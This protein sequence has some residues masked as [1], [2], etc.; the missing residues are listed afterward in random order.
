MRTPCRVSGT[1]RFLVSWA[2]FENTDKFCKGGAELDSGI[3]PTLNTL[4]PLFAGLEVS[5]TN[6]RLHPYGEMCTVGEFGVKVVALT[7]E[8]RC[9]ERRTEGGR[10]GRGGQDKVQIQHSSS[11]HINM[12]INTSRKADTKRPMKYKLFTLIVY[13]TYHALM[14]LYIGV[15]SFPCRLNR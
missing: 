11:T 8:V 5:S 13:P 6:Y 15:C 3:V 7:A 10:V 1:G 9:V 2:W 4:L 14:G 12:N